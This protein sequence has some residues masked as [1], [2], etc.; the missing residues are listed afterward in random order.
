MIF[1]TLQRRTKRLDQSLASQ[2]IAD[3]HETDK[4]HAVTGNGRLDRLAFIREEEIRLRTKV[5][6]SCVI[7]PALPDRVLAA[8]PAPLEMNERVFR[9]I[10]RTADR[11]CRAAYGREH[12]LKQPF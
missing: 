6:Q 12:I 7:E 4:R 8:G 10:L 1:V 3:Q 5:R 11:Q 9:Q 2:L